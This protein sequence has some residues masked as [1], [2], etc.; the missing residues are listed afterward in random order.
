MG[1]SFE[2]PETHTR[3]SHLRAHV[4]QLSDF[5][6]LANLLEPAEDETNED[7]DER[8]R[9]Q[10]EQ[11]GGDCIHK[12]VRHGRYVARHFSLPEPQEGVL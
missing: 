2:N 10:R 1:F 12:V 3:H 5:G 7:D 4:R 6:Y 9:Q 8:H 11:Q